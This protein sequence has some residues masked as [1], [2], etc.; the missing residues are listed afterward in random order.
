MPRIEQR[1]HFDWNIV[2]E[3]DP[4]IPVPAPAIHDEVQVEAQPGLDQYRIVLAE[5]VNRLRQDAA[6]IGGV[7]Q[8]EDGLR[9]RRP[10][11][12]PNAWFANKKHLLG[13][14]DLEYKR[15]VPPEK[16]D[17]TT[18]P[19][20]MPYDTLDEVNLRLVH[21][22]IRLH[23]KPVLIVDAK[24]NGG[25]V[26]KFDL[27]FKFSSNGEIQTHPYGEN[28]GFDL[29]PFRSRYIQTTEY[30]MWTYRMPIRGCYK[31]GACSKN[32]YWEPAGRPGYGRGNQ[33]PIR[34]ETFLKAMREGPPNYTVDKGI[35][36][37]REW[38]GGNVYSFALSAFVAITFIGGAYNIE[39]KGNRI[40]NLDPK[41]ILDGE[42]GVKLLIPDSPE[43]TSN[44]WAIRRLEDVGIQLA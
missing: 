3:I 4:P 20:Y 12:P 39:Y 29:S 41:R 33:G 27:Y 6:L 25:L 42:K 35:D 22:I 44:I 38:G 1:L 30:A 8:P 5:H 37:L 16:V 9:R 14:P 40:G 15:Y 26:N 32:T 13:E 21:S 7:N 11:P 28:T 43:V 17:M 18:R 2:D 23:D 31:Q 34:T 19:F 24:Y 36:N 10:R